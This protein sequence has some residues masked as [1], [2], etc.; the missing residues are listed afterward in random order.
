MMRVPLKGA[1]IGFEEGLYPLD[2]AD[3]G[4]LKTNW[5]A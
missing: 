1:A 2:T 5:T 3:G 4:L